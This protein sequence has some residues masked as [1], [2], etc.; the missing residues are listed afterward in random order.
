MPDDT[1]GRGTRN[2]YSP[3]R[4]G[5]D[6]SSSLE[7]FSG[8]LSGNAD[9]LKGNSTNLAKNVS[10]LDKN[11]SALLSIAKEFQE[12]EKSFKQ[13][14]DN[15]SESTKK[16]YDEQTKQAK[17]QTEDISKVLDES[18]KNTNNALTRGQKI[19]NVFLTTFETVG[20][21]LISELTSSMHRVAESYK[22]N[23]TDITVRMQ[24]SDTE[25]ASMFKDMASTF[26][27]QGL[28][29]QFSPVDYAE[30]LSETLSTGLRG[31]EAQRQAYQNLIANQLVPAI[32][33]NTREYRQMSKQFGATFT[34]GVTAISKYT[35]SIYGAE[36]LEEGKLNNVISSLETTLRYSAS[37][38][39]YTEEQVQSALDQF[40]FAINAMEQA[41][42]NTDDFVSQVQAVLEG[43][44]GDNVSTLFYAMGAGTP[45]QLEGRLMQDP[46]SVFEDYM[47]YMSLGNGN[48]LNAQ[49]TITSAIGGN[50]QVGMQVSTAENLGF[51]WGEVREEFSNYDSTAVFS[52]QMDKLRDGY[53]KTADAQLDTLEENIATPLGVLE[54]EIPRFQELTTDVKSILGVLLQMSLFTNTRNGADPDEVKGLFGKIK[55]SKVGTKVSSALSKPAAGA[56]GKAGVSTGAAVG[57]G[58][59]IVGGLIMTGKDMYDAATSAQDSGESGTELIDDLVRGG[60][61][62]NTAMTSE[63]RSSAIESA[64][65]GQ[66]QEF[67]WSEMAGNASKYALTGGGI[68]TIAGSAAGGVG[69][70]PGAAIGAAV[71]GVV[72]AAT[73]AVDQIVENYK[74][75]QLAD[76][77]NAF[78]ESLTSTTTAVDNYGKA[79]ENYEATQE[80]LKKLSGEINASESEK[81]KI[82]D[83]LKE[84]YPALLTN[85]N[86]LSDFDSEYIAVI[87]DKIEREKELAASQA[88]S[89]VSDLLD[90][91]AS[92]SEDTRD[93]LGDYLGAA[94]RGFVEEIGSE[95]KARS[96]TNKD[97]MSVADK[98]A[99][100]AGL[101]TDEFIEKLNKSKSGGFFEKVYER[102]ANGQY[103][104]DWFWAAKEFTSGDNYKQYLEDDKNIDETVYTD[105]INADY[106]RILNLVNQ[107]DELL[108]NATDDQGNV[109]LT[110][111]QLNSVEGW[112]SDLETLMN[113]FNESTSIINGAGSKIGSGDPRFDSARKLAEAAG[114]DFPNFKVGAYDIQSD[115]TLANLHEGEMVLT[116]ANAEKLRQLA[117]GG[118]GGILSALVEMTSLS[119][120]VVPDESTSE[121]LSS[122]IVSAIDSQ[123]ET[124]SG[125]LV[126]IN[127]TI[128]SLLKQPG[129]QG[130]V[131]VTEA[132]YTYEGS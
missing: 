39:E 7:R 2:P 84:Q 125:Y 91:A 68:G 35:E 76:S 117:G 37:T 11:T 9:A 103:T 108:L 6:L 17:G 110:E 29:R 87:Q 38:G 78:N 19:G 61:L 85:V 98:Y 66:K 90:E 20:K 116:S 63:D 120:S 71:G 43:G 13:D 52:D 15:F 16:S 79:V 89:S 34:Q 93:L 95:D 130:A 45:D 128:L 124:L 32:S 123:T 105:A 31:D 72:G 118:L 21:R 96:M 26:L 54:A 70:V 40:I 10:S 69:A 111:N 99:A 27:Q 109:Q 131:N 60:F 49:N 23:F 4:Q 129:G 22:S 107:F 33:T 86:D 64:L 44:V 88:V 101:S 67:D 127:N 73:N 82:L 24:W 50:T 74:F 126:T 8:A 65:S 97:L 122:A 104:G 132:A 114:V 5:S 36:G 57:G 14:L 59:M 62:G 119:S 1:K 92:A 77:V 48:G 25:Y 55:S 106:S 80:D 94:G 28:G 53:Y 51:D 41:G 102:D 12:F 115:N 47:E 56:L 113:S 83:S 58:A 42:I 81:L 112:L 100:Q 3:D 46:M 121:S 18:N 30:A 75:N